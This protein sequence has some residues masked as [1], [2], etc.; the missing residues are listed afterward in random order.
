MRNLLLVVGNWLLLMLMSCH[1]TCEVDKTVALADGLDENYCPKVDTTLKLAE[2]SIAQVNIFLE[3][4]GSMSGYM[5]LSDPATDF[6]KNIATILADLNL[7][8]TNHVTFY[9]IFNSNTPFLK[10]ENGVAKEKILKGAFSWSGSTYL[11]VMLDSI[12]RGYSKNNT[13]NIFIS[14]CI[15][16]PEK[17]D[18]KESELASS[19]IRTI[20]SPLIDS[21][22]ITTFCLFSDFRAKVG[23]ANISNKSPYYLIVQGKLEN[24][25]E[26]ERL[27]IKSFKQSSQ[28]PAEINF[29]LKYSMPYYSVL[30]YT[31]TTSNFI[32]NPCE[33]FKGAFVSIQAISLAHENDSMKFWIG[34]NLKDLP[35]YAVEQKYLDSN[36]VLTLNKGNA[37]ILA[38]SDKAPKDLASDDKPIANNSTHFILVKISQLDDCLSTMSV[39]L[40]YSRPSWVSLLNEKKDENNRDKTFGLENIVQGFEQAYYPDGKA[41]FFNNMNISL[42]KK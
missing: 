35:F 32:A 16:S 38:I 27:L 30:P 29:G 42:L 20:V 37:E 6:Q 15:Y 18:K 14:D 26:I 31:G 9:S 24:C 3:T 41:W 21:S 34:I 28:L 10:L 40:K 2:P 17:N 25:H 36:L 5:P 13:V 23:T 33:S 39:G 7:K 19:D 22:S 12:I 1:N 4:S 8:Y 11:P